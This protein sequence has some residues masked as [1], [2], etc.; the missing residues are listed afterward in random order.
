MIIFSELNQRVCNIVQKVSFHVNLH[1]VE[2]PGWNAKQKTSELDLWELKIYLASYYLNCIYISV[3]DSIF[4]CKIVKSKINTFYTRRFIFEKSS[5]AIQKIERLVP[6]CTI[7]LIVRVAIYFSLLYSIVFFSGKMTRSKWVIRSISWQWR[8]RASSPKIVWRYPRRCR[9]WRGRTRAY[10]R[11]SRHLSMRRRHSTET[12]IQISLWTANAT[13]RW[14][15]LP[16]HRKR[17][18][19]RWPRI[20]TAR[21]A[22]TAESRVARRKFQEWVLVKSLLFIKKIFS[23][24]STHIHT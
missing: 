18:R 4:N 10:R 13:S 14:S 6:Y 5:I 12:K 8:L 20:R 11:I 1:E 3:F 16:S 7:M 19:S 23:N 22:A 9:T 21:T 17:M 15:I 2:P 24:F